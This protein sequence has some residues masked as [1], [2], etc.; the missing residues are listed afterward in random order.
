MPP[1]TNRPPNALDVQHKSGAS[2]GHPKPAEP[3]TGSAEVTIPAALPAAKPPA[4]STAPTAGDALGSFGKAVATEVAAQLVSQPGSAAGVDWFG[5]LDGLSELVSGLKKRD[6]EDA[7]SGLGSLTLAL[8]G[9]LSALD[10]AAL[11]T[12]VAVELDVPPVPEPP[13]PPPTPAGKG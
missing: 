4:G 11:A 5:A 12:A 8:C 2:T 13:V 3:A 1:P 6:W 9:P 10:A 7:A